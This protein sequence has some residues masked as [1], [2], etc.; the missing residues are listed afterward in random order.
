MKFLKNS[1]LWRGGFLPI[2]DWQKDGVVVR[3]GDESKQEAEPASEG[4]LSSLPFCFSNPRQP[5]AD[6]PFGKGAFV[7]TINSEADSVIFHT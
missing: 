3:T 4:W 6:T 5:S 2:K 7:P 1:P